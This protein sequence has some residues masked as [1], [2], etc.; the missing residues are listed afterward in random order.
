MW[1]LTRSLGVVC[2]AVG[3]SVAPA[4]AQSPPPSVEPSA[5]AAPAPAPPP[6]PPESTSDI[7]AFFKST[8]IGGLLDAHFSWYTNKPEGDAS[9][10]NFDT[11]HNQ[12]RVSMAQ[13]WIAKAPA[14]D[15]RAG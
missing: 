13:L 14:P 12:F 8:E 15:S 4:A 9:F 7:A 5:A 11:R 3:L 2:T 1:R 6:A 10:R